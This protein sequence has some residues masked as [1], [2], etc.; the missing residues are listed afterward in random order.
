MADFTVRV[1]LKGDP[2]SEDDYETLHDI[3]KGL[4]F[5]RTVG[6]KKV[7]LPHGTYYGASDPGVRRSDRP[8]DPAPSR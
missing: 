2:T 6:T 7:T 8:T 3:M 4:G 1:E 5:G